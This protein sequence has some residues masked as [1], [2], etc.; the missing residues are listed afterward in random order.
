MA[1]IVGMIIMWSGSVA[2]IPSGWRFCDGNFG[3]PNLTGRFIIAATN[4]NTNT[5][6]G[7]ASTSV[8]LT[9]SNMPS[10]YHSLSANATVTSTDSGHTHTYKSGLSAISSNNA[11]GGYSYAADNDRT[12]V[13]GY[14][15][16]SSS[17]SGNTDSAGG[18]TAFS[19]AI[20]PLYY[21]LAY[22]LYTG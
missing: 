1:F 22:I 2:T 12:T 15:N 3:T 16:I 13:T 18:G 10:H 14:A 17:I 8:T 5:T 21:S 19:V 6:G 9:T 4:D 7:A 20:I 11:A